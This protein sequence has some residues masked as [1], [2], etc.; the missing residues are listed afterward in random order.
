[1]KRLMIKTGIKTISLFGLFAVLFPSVALA[2]YQ[3]SDIDPNTSGNCITLNQ[4]L[5]QGSDDTL[6][7]NNEVR[8]LQGALVRLGFLN[9]EPTGY[10]GGATF[11]AV[12]NF[13]SSNNIQPTG[14]VGSHTR[15][16]VRDRTCNTN[17]NNTSTWNTACSINT[18][19]SSSNYCSCPNGYVKEYTNNYNTSF[20]CKVK[21]NI[22]PISYGNNVFTDT[23]CTCPAGYTKQAVTTNNTYG[24]I[25]TGYTCVYNSS[26]SGT[27]TNTYTQTY[28]YTTYNPYSYSYS[29][30][31]YYNYYANQ[32]HTC[33]NGV[34]VTATQGCPY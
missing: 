16:T 15:S 18:T 25:T 7:G 20:V 2:Q 21:P 32:T 10:F 19:L 26:Y 3:Y 9:V 14:F 8:K 23:T 24:P 22:C 4:D 31:T 5:R 11:N 27:Y 30:N 29:A 34:V 6:N 1:M 17:S 13:Q 12:K 28:P 33:S